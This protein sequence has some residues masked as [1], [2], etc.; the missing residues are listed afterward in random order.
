GLRAERPVGAQ[1]PPPRTKAPAEGG[2]LEMRLGTYWLVRVGI[3]MVLIGLVFFG[4]LAYHNYISQ[5]GAGG[6]VSLLYFASLVLLGGGW[7]WQRQAVKETLRNYAQVLFAGG[8][9]AFYFTTYAAHHLE[10]LRVITS[11]V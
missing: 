2:S 4:N 7:W 1:A 8:L 5:L 9:A 3:V 6:K 10:Q 11:P